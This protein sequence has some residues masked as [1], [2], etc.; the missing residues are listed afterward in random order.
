MSSIEH[1]ASEG[2]ISSRGR[3][4]LLPF[5]ISTAHSAYN[6]SFKKY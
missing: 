2:A 3:I 4:A 5:V 1:S 6:Q